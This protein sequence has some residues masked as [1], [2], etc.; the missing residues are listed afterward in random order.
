VHVTLTQTDADSQ[1]APTAGGVVAGPAATPRL[2]AVMVA[3]AVLSSIVAIT[4]AVV[5][6]T[7]GDRVGVLA[8]RSGR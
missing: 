2:V 5:L 6:I 1:L 7:A 8:K 4:A 3:G